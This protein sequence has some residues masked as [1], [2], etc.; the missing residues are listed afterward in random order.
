MKARQPCLLTIVLC[1]FAGANFG[2]TGELYP[3]GSVFPLVL[4]DVAPSHFS[5]VKAAG[6]NTVHIYSSMQSVAEAQNYLQEAGKQ[7]LFVMQNMPSSNSPSNTTFWQSFVNGVKGFAN[8]AWWYL[9]EEETAAHQQPIAAVVH[10]SD[11]RPTASYLPWDAERTLRGY[12]SFLEVSTKGSYPNYYGEPRVNCVSWVLSHLQAFPVVAPALE[13]FGDLPSPGEA[14]YDA[15]ASVIAGAKGLSWYSYAYIKNNEA[16]WSGLKRIAYEMEGAGNP[17]PVGQ[18]VLSARTIHSVSYKVLSG[19]TESPTTYGKRFP[20]IMV[21]E[22]EYNGTIYLLA[23]NNA[24]VY[25]RRASYSDATVTVEFTVPGGLVRALALFEDG[26][27]LAITDAVFTDSF[28]PLDVHVY[29]LETAVG[30]SVA[31]FSPTGVQL[32]RP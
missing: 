15:Y 28:E 29:K 25:P 2:Q 21:V 22:K 23:V 14:R 19:P 8:L 5:R 20:S 13:A 17:D 12:Q 32:E 7:G 30:D 31:P 3:R 26:R 4:Y 18:I 6:F 11:G 27:S 10:D 24:Q 1:G 16:F 9:P